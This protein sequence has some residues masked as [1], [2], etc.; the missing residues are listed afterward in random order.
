[1]E[2]RS[3]I[4]TL[5]SRQGA[6]DFHVP[7]IQLC[8]WTREQTREQGSAR[9]LSEADRAAYG[10]TN[11]GNT[12]HALPCA[13]TVNNTNQRSFPDETVA[14]GHVRARGDERSGDG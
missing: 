6:S 1:V 4:A 9:R 8:E 11:A 2:L 12:N 5:N 14:D 10:R 7:R 3:G 13:L